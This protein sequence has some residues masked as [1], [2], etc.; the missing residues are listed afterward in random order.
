MATFINRSQYTVRVLHKPA[1]KRDFPHSELAA[2]HAYLKE[3][4]E[5]GHPARL[6]QGDDH[7]YVRI[8]ADSLRAPLGSYALLV[9]WLLKRV[10]H[11]RSR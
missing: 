6:A 8:R 2:A 5:Q 1:L 10:L 11:T 9:Y 3:L 4:R 7:W